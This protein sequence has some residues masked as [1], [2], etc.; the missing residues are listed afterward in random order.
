[1]SVEVGRSWAS[2]EVQLRAGAGVQKP[3]GGRFARDFRPVSAG[4]SAWAAVPSVADDVAGVD[5]GVGRT[6]K[7]VQCFN[8]FVA[9]E[10]R[11]AG[12]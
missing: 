9:V 4:R 8:G 2:A 7:G 1:M 5:G 3:S 6:L 10:G 12:P 11:Q